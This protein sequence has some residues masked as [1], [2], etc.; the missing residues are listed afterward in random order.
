MGAGPRAA[1]AMRPRFARCVGKQHRGAVGA[2]P[3]LEHA[4][5]RRNDAIGERAVAGE[6]AADDP[7]PG[8]SATVSHARN[9]VC[10]GESDHRLRRDRLGLDI[11]AAG[12]LMNVA[13]RKTHDL[14][15]FDGQKRPVADAN[16]AGSLDDQMV[17]NDSGGAGREALCYVR[18]R[19]RLHRPWRSQ[20]RVDEGRAAK[21]DSAQNLGEC[22]HTEQNV[23]SREAKALWQAAR[24]VKRSTLSES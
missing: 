10:T 20:L 1:L 18:G 2:D 24:A 8:S 14:R 5:E 15:R 7:R 3:E 17:W 16:F 22:I 11:G 13:V 19:G 12:E 6:E 23:P 21:A 9:L 4:R